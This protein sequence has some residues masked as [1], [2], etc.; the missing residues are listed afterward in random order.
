LTHD[1]RAVPPILSRV[2]SASA[3]LFLLRATKSAPPRCAPSVFKQKEDAVTEDYIV[4]YR[5]RLRDIV[6]LRA[7]LC[8]CQDPDV[9][10][11]LKDLIQDEYD[12]ASM[13]MGID[14][15]EDWLRR[16]SEG[17]S[18]IESLLDQAIGAR[19][20]AR[21]LRWEKETIAR[22]LREEAEIRKLREAKSLTS[23]IVQRVSRILRLIHA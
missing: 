13:T 23:R 17:N 7:K 19:S 15:I 12:D 5:A 3:H 21:D 10:T 4:K 2:R 16:E 6:K 22:E 9:R 14:C 20:T 11:Y 18:Q 1:L 8:C